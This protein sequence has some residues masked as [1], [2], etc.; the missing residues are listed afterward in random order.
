MLS[1]I[2]SQREQHGFSMIEI[3]VSTVVLAV[4]LLGF[5]SLQVNGLKNN[6]SAYYR[7]QATQLAYDIADRMRANPN[8][9][10]DYLS[11]NLLAAD[12]VAQPDCLSTDG[13]SSSE[14]AIHD[15]FEWHG[16]LSTQLP[17]GEGD[18]TVQTDIYTITVFW[19]ENRDG[20]TDDNDPHFA[21]SFQ[22]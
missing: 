15:L 2:Y 10:T 11:T 3:L 19:D 6:Q 5:A 14:M 4:G 9:A 13:C 12:A 21:M 22:L 17:G 18:I 20:I 1:P 16:I 7:S 8:S